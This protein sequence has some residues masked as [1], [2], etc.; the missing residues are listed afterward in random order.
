MAGNILGTGTRM[1]RPVTWETLN[2]L[3]GRRYRDS[4]MPG[5][6]TISLGVMQH[7][8]SILVCEVDP[9]N[10]E[11]STNPSGLGELGY[12]RRGRQLLAVRDVVEAQAEGLQAGN[13]RTEP[14]AARVW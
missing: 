14:A 8:R 13:P 4:F 11:G 1:V 3:S 9:E 10:H 2:T 6:G 7:M 5:S 12:A